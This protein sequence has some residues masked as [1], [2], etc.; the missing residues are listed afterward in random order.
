V[1]DQLQNGAHDVVGLGEDALELVTRRPLEAAHRGYGA[2]E[3]REGLGNAISVPPAGALVD[4]EHVRHLE[5]LTPFLRQC[6]PQSLSMT[7]GGKPPVATGPQRVGVIRSSALP[8]LVMAAR[9]SSQSGC[10]PLIDR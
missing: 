8:C 4:G 7:S 2:A 5:S 1:P 6:K 3:Q 9:Y 10:S